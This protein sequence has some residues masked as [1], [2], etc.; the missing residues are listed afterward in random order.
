MG[1]HTTN[2]QKIYDSARMQMY[3]IDLAVKE[4]NPECERAGI[5][6]DCLAYNNI[7]TLP[8]TSE[9][10]GDVKNVMYQ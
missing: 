7:T 2:T 6:A 5:K 9:K 4:L 10:W 3:E 1:K 8:N